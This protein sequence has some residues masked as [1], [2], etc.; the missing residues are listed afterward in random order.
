MSPCTT[1]SIQQ[2]ILCPV[3][4]KRVSHQP[5]EHSTKT[6]AVLL[7]WS[8]GWGTPCRVSLCMRL[9]VW[10]HV[11]ARARS[12][13][14]PAA[15]LRVQRHRWLW[16]CCP[17]HSLAWVSR[18][19]HLIPLG[20][21][22]DWNQLLR[23]WLRLL[24]QGSLEW[25]EGGSLNRGGWRLSHWR[26]FLP[27]CCCVLGLRRWRWDLG[28]V[29]LFCCWWSGFLRGRRRRSLLFWV[30]GRWLGYSMSLGIF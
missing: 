16:Q 13:G 19:W 11:W 18:R 27:L 26:H 3:S 20:A 14:C 28:L 30:A 9:V 1:H 7:H 25:T 4:C 8:H 21:G 22:R 29:C 17:R 12:G 6:R 10:G 15:A 24:W 2:K 5:L 23:R